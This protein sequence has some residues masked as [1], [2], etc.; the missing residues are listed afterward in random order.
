L[1]T[2]ETAA[3]TS[4]SIR[5]GIREFVEFL[6]K[7]RTPVNEKPIVMTGERDGISVEIAVQ[8]NDAYTETTFSFA[9]NINTVEGGTH[10][11]GFRAALTRTINHY[12]SRNSM[13]EKLTE[14]ISG[15]DIREGM[16]AV[17]SVKIPQPQ[18]KAR[19]RPSSATPRSRASSRP[20]STTG[21]ARFWR[22]RRRSPNAS[23]RRPSKPRWRVRPRARPAISSD[24]RARWTTR[25]CPGSWRIARSE[26][27]RRAKSTSSK[28][29]PQAAQP[30][31]AA[32][33]NSRRC[34]PSKAN[35]ERR[36]GP[37]RQDARHEEIRTII[38]ALGC[39]IG[40]DEFDASKLRTTASSS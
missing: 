29:N 28:V 27:R 20:S 19:P 34:C 25:R 35:P 17:I 11:S 9:N 15:D 14:S 39:G 36:K 37:L 7:N 10:L 23:S 26:T 38:A 40:Q 21:W 2:S 22:R 32:I 31:R 4:F 12:A 16:A 24:A 33:G 6:N 3:A 1:T 18:L 30:S 13:A 8:W 5:A